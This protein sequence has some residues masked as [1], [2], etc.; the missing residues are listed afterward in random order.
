MTSYEQLFENNRQ[1]VSDHIAADPLHFE[2]LA[3]GQRPNFLF[4]GCSD[5]R[6]P[7]DQI[8]GTNAGEM[9]V[10]RNIANLVVYTDM[11]LMAV[12]Q[13]AVEVLHVEHVIVC[14]HYGCGGVAAA[15]DGRFHGLIDKWLR[16]I[17]D[18]YRLHRDELNG[19]DDADHRLRRLVEVN[20]AEQ[21]FK[22]CSTSIIQ[23][24]WHDERALHVHGWV[25]DIRDGLIRD[26]EVDVEREFADSAQIY[27]YPE[28]RRP[29]S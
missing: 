18:T 28:F 12:L 2:R 17:K 8:T 7:A 29:P 6:V 11:N 26:L 13:Y 19:I 9:F 16:N 15:V 27:D 25:Y 4:I 24:A 10:H 23:R 22:L 5:S 14:G 21:V 3:D 20:V 1:W